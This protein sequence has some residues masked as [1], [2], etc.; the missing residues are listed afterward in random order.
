MDK[1]SKIL[2]TG[3]TGQIGSELTP[4]LRRRYGAENV[5]AGLH[6]K[7]PPR[8]M[9]GE[10][11]AAT[12]DVT[13]R[14]ALRQVVADH[15]ADTIV[16]LAG[17]LSG[18]GEQHPALAWDVNVGG[19]RN[20]L[21]VAKEAGV[22]QVFVP[23]SIAVF[24]A[25]CPRDQTPQDTVL[26]PST[27][28]GITK[29]AG[30]LLGEYY[31]RRYGLDVRGL[32]LPGI[33]SSETPPGGG[34]TDYAVEIFHAAVQDG[35]YTCFLT[36]DTELPMLYMPDCLK[37][38]LDLLEA[39]PARLVHHTGFNVTGF[40]VTPARLADAIRR[41]LPAFTIA[42]APDFRQA[43]ADSWPHSLDDSAARAEWG[44]RPAFDLEAMTAGMLTKLRERLGSRP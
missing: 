1:S 28:Y 13:Q 18:A 19:L 7:A 6:A 4:A 2:V 9:L 16:H 44:W 11:P 35:D 10:G 37:A 36:P 29:V 40:S 24:G 23:S 33:I 15:H 31:V 38:I 25:G 22:R 43:I 12:V 17:I 14:D 21:E 27:M 32:R 42:Y 5:V 3:A 41:H 26:Q 39:D 20:V 8:G 34:T 30:E